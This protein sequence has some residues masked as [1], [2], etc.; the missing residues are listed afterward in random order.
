MHTYLRY[1]FV[2]FRCKFTFVAIYTFFGVNFFCL[3]P[4]FCFLKHIF[5]GRCGEYVASFDCYAVAMGL[6]CSFYAV[7]M[8][9]LCVCNGVAMQFLCDCYAMKLIWNCFAV[10]MRLLCFCYVIAMW[11]L[12]CCYANAMWLLW[13]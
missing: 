12:Y 3:K 13:S 2:L 4:N 1:N 6:L 10:A 7:A 8:R 9:L 11:L 5:V